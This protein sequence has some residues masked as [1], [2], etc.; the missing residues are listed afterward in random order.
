MSQYH[1][2]Q[3]KHMRHSENP[4]D[5]WPKDLDRNWSLCRKVNKASLRLLCLEM[6]ACKVNPWVASGNLAGKVSYIDIKHTLTNKSG[7][8]RLNYLYNVVYGKNVLYFW[9][10]RTLVHAKQIIPTW[11]DPSKSLGHRVSNGLPWAE[12]SHSCCYIFIAGWSVCCLWLP[13]GG[14]KHE[15]LNGLFHMSFSLMIQLCIFTIAHCCN[16]CKSVTICKS[17]TL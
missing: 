17:I 15:T 11:A 12:N 9:E 5:F 8:L 1:P 3:V 2:V 7:L 13:M 16:K 10:S 14:R 4:K 6:P